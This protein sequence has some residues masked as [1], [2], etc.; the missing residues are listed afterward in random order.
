MAHISS[1]SAGK[2]T[3]LAYRE[4]PANAAA[5]VIT[6]ASTVDDMATYFTTA[7]SNNLLASVEGVASATSDQPAPKGV[8]NVR[9]FPSLGTPANVVN[10]PVYGQATS[11][12]IAGQSDAPSLDFTVNYI[13][14]EHGALETLRKN[15][16]SLVF[17][18]RISDAELTLSSG[19]AV[20][21]VQ[22]SFDD[23]YFLGKIASLEITPGLTDANQATMSLTIEGDFT[24]PVSLVDAAS[25]PESNPGVYNQLV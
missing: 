10:V 4:N 3:T 1:L 23:F 2:F 15:A 14:S 7:P 25:A 19:V 16:T 8:G 13:P 24:G 5:G 9:E 18:V 22:N 21:S 20:A 11:S 17:R 6:S 12:Q